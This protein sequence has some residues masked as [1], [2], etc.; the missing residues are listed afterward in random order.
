[1]PVSLIKLE[2]AGWFELDVVSWRWTYHDSVEGLFTVVEEAVKLPAGVEV[3]SPCFYELEQ[4]RPRLVHIVLPLG[5][6]GCLAVP[7]VNQLIADL[8]SARHSLI[9]D[10][11][12][13]ASKLLKPV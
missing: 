1:M 8:V 12:S 11:L 13:V 2:V 9:S 3:L 4:V 7:A 5:D 10:S 6:G